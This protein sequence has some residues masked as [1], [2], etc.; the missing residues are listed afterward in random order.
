MQIILKQDVENL[1]LEFDTIDVKPGFARNFLI[2]QGIALLATPKNRADLAATLE[3]RKAIEADIVAKAQATIATLKT[4]SLV[5]I[6]KVGAGDK[7][8]GSITNITVAEELA[9]LGLNIDKKFIK[10]PGN[11]IKRAGKFTAKV[12]LHRD[13]E[14]DYE[15]EIAAEAAKEEKAVEA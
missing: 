12:R 5:I 10:I 1:G 2:P 14:L 9:K 15:F 6:A 8:F 11:S 7:L 4:K 13:V 3:A